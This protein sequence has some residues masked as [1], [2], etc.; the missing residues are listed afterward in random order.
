MSSLQ[1]QP[2]VRRILATFAQPQPELSTRLVPYTSSTVHYRHLFAIDNSRE[3]GHF[4]VLDKHGKLGVLTREVFR[5][6]AEEGRVAHLGGRWNI[7]AALATYTGT[8]MVIWKWTKR[9]YERIVIK[10]GTR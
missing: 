1:A 9:E 2:E 4:V 7:H 8:G 10:D 5:A 3:E 6:I